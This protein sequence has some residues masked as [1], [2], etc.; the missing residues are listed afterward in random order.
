MSFKS[1]SALP[2][3]TRHPSKPVRPLRAAAAERHRRQQGDPHPAAGRE[4]NQ[5]VLVSTLH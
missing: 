1:N 3:G 5:V 4:R 2:L